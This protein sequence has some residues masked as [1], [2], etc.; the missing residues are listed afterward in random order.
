MLYSLGRLLQLA[1]MIC[2]PLGIA[3]NISEKISVTAV[4]QFT[5][6]G[7]GLFVVG[8]WMQQASGKK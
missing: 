6:V 8:Y 1:G 3:G 2:L 7:I 5:I 4:Y